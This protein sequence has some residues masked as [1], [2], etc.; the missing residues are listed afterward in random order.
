MPNA[1]YYAQ[2]TALSLRRKMTGFLNPA[3][4][5]E[6]VLDALA[7][8]PAMVVPFARVRRYFSSS[9]MRSAIVRW[10]HSAP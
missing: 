1:S 8:L 4:G 10:T 6:E 2:G 3:Q 5:A 9:N 7:Q